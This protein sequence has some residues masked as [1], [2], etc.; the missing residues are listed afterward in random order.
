MTSDL[1][2]L[3]S[4][5]VT[6]T[7]HKCLFKARIYE[8]TTHGIAFVVKHFYVSVASL[9]NHIEIDLHFTNDVS[10]FEESRRSKGNHVCSV[11]PYSIT[12]YWNGSLRENHS[13]QQSGS[14]SRIDAIEPPHTR[15]GFGD[16]V[17]I[18]QHLNF[19]CIQTKSVRC[20][21]R[22]RCADSCC[23]SIH[24][25]AT[26]QVITI[27]TI[28]ASNRN[29]NRRVMVCTHALPIVA[30]CK[31]DLWNSI[32]QIMCRIIIIQQCIY[33]SHSGTSKNDLWSWAV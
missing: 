32:V 15:V 2:S 12:G 30:Y 17:F 20:F 18:N 9:R 1:I 28:T 16:D 31:F 29:L 33:E 7:I 22:C 3:P 25:H 8:A 14:H 19:D 13:F 6:P 24:R 27:K 10:V 23:M 5:A 26:V 21:T 4:L 11:S